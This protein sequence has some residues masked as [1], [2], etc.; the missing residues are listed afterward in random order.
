MTE[1]HTGKVADDHT[2]V[3]VRAVRET[4]HEFLSYILLFRDS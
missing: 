2:Y 4:N 3:A 1:G